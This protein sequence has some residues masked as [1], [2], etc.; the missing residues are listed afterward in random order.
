MAEK[1]SSG[2]ENLAS[3][4]SPLDFV[5]QRIC[6][7]VQR[8]RAAGRPLKAAWHA[9]ARRLGLTPRRVRAFHYHEVQEADVRAAELLAAHAD[10]QAELG[11]LERRLGEIRGL[12]DVD[13]DSA[14][15]RMA[16]GGVLACGQARGGAGCVLDARGDKNEG[17]A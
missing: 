7:E 1:L 15:R 12:I 17:S 9:V 14:H 13:V 8:E 5:E 3:A 2:A 11:A 16:G 10:L 6:A 4:V